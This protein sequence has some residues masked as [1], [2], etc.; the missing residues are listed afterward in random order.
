VLGTVGYR[1][2][3]QGRGQAEG[4]ASDLFSFGAVLYETLT[5]KRA[6]RGETAADTMSSI[7]KEDPQELSEARGQIPPALKCIVRHCLEKV[8]RNDFSRRA[9]S[10]L[11]GKRFPRVRGRRRWLLA[12]P[13]CGSRGASSPQFR[14]FA[15]LAAVAAAAFFADHKLADFFVA[16]AWGKCR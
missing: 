6:F 10:P 12:R 1:S 9:M 3:E 15:A 14:D 13:L 11:I 7:L 2:P 8:R 5:G 16:L 4:P